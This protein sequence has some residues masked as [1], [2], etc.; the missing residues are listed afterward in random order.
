MR[1]LN[2]TKEESVKKILNMSVETSSQEEFDVLLTELV[3]ELN[4]QTVLSSDNISLSDKIKSEELN[5][6]SRD[7][8]LD[9]FIAFENDKNISK[10]IQKI[11]IKS[12]NN[13]NILSDDIEKIKTINDI[14]KSK[15]N[16]LRDKII[17]MFDKNTKQ[18][19]DNLIPCSYNEI[20]KFITLPIEME[21][22][23]LVNK[24]G[25]INGLITEKQ[26]TGN[27][28]VYSNNLD[29]II[30]YSKETYYLKE[31]YTNK[32][33][34]VQL[35]DFNKNTQGIISTFTI[36]LDSI[37]EIN[38]LVIQPFC[39]YP[40]DIVSIKI[41]DI[42]GNE[43][44]EIINDNVL[45]ENDSIINFHSYFTDEIKITVQQQN[46]I[47]KK[48]QFKKKD[49]IKEKLDSL[50]LDKKEYKKALKT[51]KL[52]NINKL[53]D[54]FT[55]DD[56]VE[57]IKNKYTIGFKH[58]GVYNKKFKEEGVF[59]SEEYQINEDY[60]YLE[61]EIDKADG[62]V[63]DK[64]ITNEKIKIVSTED[65]KE[66]DILPI[67]LEEIKYEKLKP[68]GF[69]NFETQ[70]PIKEIVKIY[71]NNVEIGFDDFKKQ[72]NSENNQI[73][74]TNSNDFF[75]YHI[76][77][78]PQHKKFNYK[79]IDKEIK[80]DGYNKNSYSI[81]ENINE[82]TI[83][84]SVQIKNLKTNLSKSID[85]LRDVS[86]EEGNVL[87]DDVDIT[88]FSIVDKEHFVIMDN[89][90]IFNRPINEYEQVILNITNKMN[91]FKIKIEMKR[92]VKN[93]ESISN[94]INWYKLY[95]KKGV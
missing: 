34:R 67:N 28:I 73:N 40:M 49:L 55:T 84:N 91:K 33:V 70:F 25:Q 81:N 2:E 24:S 13:K 19:K 78:K 41:K 23:N 80:I 88:D 11:N 64:V 54:L 83:I 44:V 14:T 29:Y 57:T 51:L 4:K 92:N 27:Q 20:G 79:V 45:L 15:N 22:N 6:I 46:F 31:I 53:K 76:H 72:N 50:S 10:E 3:N 89:N 32:A 58:I 86:D 66:Y 12:E 68:V 52:D 59:L 82:E 8:F 56:I 35:D 38:Q 71:E 77:Y 62:L 30:D 21:E 85:N 47:K 74:I 42:Y 90:I 75:D 17:N 39:E 5:K 95:A 26:L 63:G 61:L 48:F 37:K 1:N 36:T 93:S 87:G 16:F 60:D 43:D 69:K 18:E 7:L 9:L 94:K 65:N